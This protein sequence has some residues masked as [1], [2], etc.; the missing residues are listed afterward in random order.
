[1]GKGF[2]DCESLVAL[3]EMALHPIDLTA[4]GCLSEERIQKNSLSAEG[5]TYSYATERV[6][7]RCLEALQGLTEE[8]ELIKQ[9]ECMQQGAIMN[10]IEGF[11][12]ESRPD[13]IRQH[14]LGFEIKI[15]MKKLLR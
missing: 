1:M 3:Q 10:R 4:S 11:Q 2:L 12:S 14:A 9:M 5:F 15:F 13:C 7:D 8:R 6:D